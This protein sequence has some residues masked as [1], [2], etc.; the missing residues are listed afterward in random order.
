MEQLLFS[1]G[2]LLA[3]R[4]GAKKLLFV[5]TCLYSIALA[6]GPRSSQAD[7]DSIG[8]LRRVDCFFTMGKSGGQP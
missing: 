4:L 2:R 3:L 8:V 5:M 6:I 1:V 7:A